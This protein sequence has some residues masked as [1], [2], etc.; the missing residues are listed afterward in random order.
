[1]KQ[2][3][4]IIHPRNEQ[5]SD[6]SKNVSYYLDRIQLLGNLYNYDVDNNAM[7]MR[8]FQEFLDLHDS[9]N[10]TGYYKI[11]ERMTQVCP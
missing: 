1:M 5:D 2:K 4:L 10:G 9:D 6:D 8:V 3:N 11:V 7:A